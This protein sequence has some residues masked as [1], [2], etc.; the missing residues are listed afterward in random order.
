M[1]HV[2]ATV[3][4]IVLAALTPAGGS[5]QEPEADPAT[6]F[7]DLAL[8]LPAQSFIIV[9]D[10]QGQRTTGRLIGI[11]G[12]ALSLGTDRALSFRQSD[13]QQVQRKIPDRILDGGL[14]GF[15]IGM[16]GPLIVCTSISD[17]SETSACA[18]GSVAFGGL[19]GFAI[20]ALIDR[21]RSRTVTLFRRSQ[22]AP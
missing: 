19:P 9:T 15:A 21:A 3:F 18:L 22:Q 1:R 4:A 20:G 2:K 6:T 14:I 12:D 7:S 17:S 11:D 13:V 10:Q 16:A 5:A 8:R